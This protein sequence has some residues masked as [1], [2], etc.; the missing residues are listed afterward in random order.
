[1]DN[2]T[3]YWGLSVSTRAYTWSLT[4]GGKDT[5]FHKFCQD[6]NSRGTVLSFKG[7]VPEPP[8]GGLLD[9]INWRRANWG[10]QWDT[11]GQGD[12]EGRSITFTTT[13]P[14]TQWY[15]SVCKRYLELDFEFHETS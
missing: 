4:V 11:H 5:D 7:T 14:A 8:Y 6:A 9:R 15:E 3:T 13:G 12:W 2:D 10:T 1:M